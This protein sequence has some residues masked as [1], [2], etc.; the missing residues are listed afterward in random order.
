M[1]N[2]FYDETSD[3]DNKWQ[4]CTRSNIGARCRFNLD[5]QK[6][7]RDMFLEA[8][9]N[10]DLTWDKLDRECCYSFVLEQH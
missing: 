3:D 10:S 4:I 5:S 1:V 9:V 8:A 2:I 7:F 6:T